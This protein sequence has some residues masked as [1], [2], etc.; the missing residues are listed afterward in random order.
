[1]TFW[2]EYLPWYMIAGMMFA[3]LIERR[4]PLTDGQW[5]MMVYGWLVILPI[6]FYRR[7]FT[8][9]KGE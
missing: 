4:E 9:K 3:R 1:M 5:L 2:L 7:H 6:G 8:T